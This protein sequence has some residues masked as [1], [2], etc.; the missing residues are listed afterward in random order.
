M[1][2]EA[3]VKLFVKHGFDKTSTANISRKAGVATGTLFVHFKSKEELIGSIYNET[4]RDMLESIR[5]D[6]SDRDTLEQIIRKSCRNGIFWGLEN[7]DKIRFVFQVKSSPYVSLASREMQK[8]DRHYRKLLRSGSRQKILKK[9]PPDY[10][11]DVLTSH[12]S[13]SV[14]YLVS[15][16]SK[17]H[18]LVDLFVD[19]IWDSIRY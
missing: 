11:M 5:H 10:I 3:A 8:E 19:S 2:V 15:N 6:I 1:I 18:K 14:D 9:L 16:K 13:A 7:Y 17:D 4:K 12:V